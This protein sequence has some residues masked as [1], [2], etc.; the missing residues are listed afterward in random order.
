MEEEAAIEAALI[1]EFD[2]IE[3][4]P[5]RTEDPKPHAAVTAAPLTGGAP[6]YPSFGDLPAAYLSISMHQQS[7]TNSIGGSSEASLHDSQKPQQTQIAQPQLSHMVQEPL[8]RAGAAPVGTQIPQSKVGSEAIPEMTDAEFEAQRRL[9][10]RE[11]IASQTRMDHLAHALMGDTPH[12]LEERGRRE[13]ERAEREER[14]HIALEQRVLH[15]LE[16]AHEREER[17]IKITQRASQASRSP[18]PEPQETI[19]RQSSH[20]LMTRDE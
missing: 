9:V 19:T 11:L 4:A 2:V 16:R 6:L 15:Q 17:R 12:Q 18:S 5:K 14:R 20:D 13:H 10:E 8:M 7:Q 1:D 3:D